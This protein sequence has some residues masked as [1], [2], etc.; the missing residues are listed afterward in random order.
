MIPKLRD[1][2]TAGVTEVQQKYIAGYRAPLFVLPTGGGKTIFFSYIAHTAAIRGKRVLIVVHRVELLE[3]T[4]EKLRMF[5]VA[6]GAISPAHTPL[7]NAPV[8]VCMVQSMQKRMQ[9]Y[10]HFDLIIT[11]ECHHIAAASYLNIIKAYPNAYQLGVTATPVRTDGKGL[12]NHAGGIYDSIV[13]G[14]S[15]RDL[16]DMGFL[17][18]PVV[19][20]PPTL[21]DMVGVRK[22]GGDYSRKDI[23]ERTD[24]KAITGN[25]VDHYLDTCR[26]QPGV[27]FCCSV[28]HAEHVAQEFRD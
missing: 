18:Q 13:L 1:Y 6:C 23:D 17:V 20:S 24:K 9:F 28:K 14:P 3:Q 2:Q 4:L 27:V 19:Y 22:S 11:D 7:Y 5:G 8:Q 16:I 25:A 12:G 15:T 10:P 26:N 21:V